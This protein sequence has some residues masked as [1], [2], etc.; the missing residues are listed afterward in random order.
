[1]HKRTVRISL[2]AVVLSGVC[3]LAAE[4]PPKQPA[5]PP[6]R[7][8]PPDRG[9]LY[10]KAPELRRQLQLLADADT[11]LKQRVEILG[12]LALTREARAVPLL[13]KLV[14]AGSGVEVDVP[15]P[16]TPDH[17]RFAWVRD[18]PVGG[19]VPMDLRVAA[20]WALGE[21]GDPRGVVAFQHALHNIY[22]DKPEWRYEK[23]VTLADG[24]KLSLR[25]L[26]E[27][28][29]G[30]LAEPLVDKY[31][32]FLLAPL[33]DG[34]FKPTS[35]LAGPRK[36]QPED[37]RRRAALLCLAAVGD[38]DIRAVKALCQVLRADDAY[39]PWDFKVIAAQALAGLV[40][41]RREEF[42][43][44]GKVDDPMADLVA[45]AFIEA[46]IITELPEVREV[47][48]WT[49]RRLGWADRAGARLAE[50]LDTP[51][52]PK[53]VRFRT[54]EFLAFIRSDAA[55]DELIFHLYDEDVNVRWRA[56]IA[57]GTTGDPRAVP[58]LRKLTRDREP[59]VRLKAVAALG[60]MEAFNALPDLAV[61]I[62][63]PDHRVRRAAALALGRVGR[64]EGIPAL[65]R[66]LQDPRAS[67]RANAVI[68]LGMIGRV[69]GLKAVPKLIDDPE[70][71]VRQVVARVLSRFLNPG[72]TGALLR[73]LG[74][75]DA[76]VRATAGS[77]IKQRLAERPR[78]TVPLVIRAVQKTEGRARAGALEC[79]VQHYDAVRGQEESAAARLY[80]R[81]LRDAEEPLLAGLLAALRDKSP[82][83][84]FLAADVLASLAWERKDKS[85]LER[86]ASLAS[87]PN[88][89]VA[90]VGRRARNYLANLRR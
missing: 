80:Q 85:L 64:D 79:F 73:A 49:L 61:A 43:R 18:L 87:D 74:D 9:R 20:L 46:G 52:I 5:E 2:L 66:A 45:E 53:Q 65:H 33:T 37:G 69:P 28:H 90:R 24:R 75:E 6:D 27:G 70:P 63:D 58:F 81:G 40:E 7:E 31:S 67:V 48:G 54:I 8:V 11:A 50:V 26:C 30:R 89:K 13:V 21:I 1:M 12:V 14:L 29:L 57:L 10:L 17:Q 77:A 68:A 55:A 86:V 84:R 44:L 56:A 39:Y 22:L 88:S 41:R 23:G 51:N 78:E 4:A 59:F 83:A 36:E 3:G 62:E 19:N 34:S 15:I 71:A 72:A 32:D 35:P 82:R 60:H 25:E 47:C 16:P 76:Q 38:R 42:K